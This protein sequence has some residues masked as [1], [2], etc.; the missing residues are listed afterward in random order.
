MS[1]A[2][3]LAT[4]VSTGNVLADGTVAYSE[5]SG[6]PTLATVATSGAYADVTGTPTL[7]TVATSGS[8]TDLTD[9]PTI[10]ATATNIAGGSNGTIPYQTAADTTAML[11]VG[12]AGQVLQTNGAGAPSWVTPA[13]GAMV[14]LSTVTASNSATVDLETTFDSTYDNYLITITGL[15][16]T[17]DNVQ[18]YARL[19]ISGAY[20]TT[21]SYN[22]SFMNTSVGHITFNTAASA[23]QIELSRAGFRTDA[24]QEQGG[25]VYVQNPAGTTTRCL[26]RAWLS[27][28][29][30]NSY[31]SLLGNGGPQVS[32]AVT[33]VR[34][35][36]SSGNISVG[37]FRLYGIANS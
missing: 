22:S 7:A 26:L 17:V 18:L 36:M 13:G 32:T 23:T 16:P 4:T 33:G 12:T 15:T 8:Y 24:N 1:K 5:V 30:P 2:K 31:P 34:L 37:T 27:F 3:T 21:G 11:A 9:K 29:G 25:Q 20:V 35:F 6:T 10:L 14:L 28:D 19:K